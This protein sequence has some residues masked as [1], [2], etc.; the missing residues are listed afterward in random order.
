[1]PRFAF[2]AVDATGARRDGTEQAPSEAA[3]LRQLEARGLYALD[4]AERPDMRA[5][6]W[7][8][9]RRRRDVLEAT[10]AMAALLPAGLPLARALAESAQVTGLD[11]REALDDVR[12]RIERGETL[13]DALRA[14]PAHFPAFYVGIV[15]AGERS[16]DV[17]AAFGQLAA[18]L[19]R[20]EALRGRVLSATLYPAL[21]AVVGS[22][23]ILVLLGVVLPRFTTLLLDTGATLPRST[24]ALM[25][26]SSALRTAGPVLALALAAALVALVLLPRSPAGRRLG[27]EWLL[28][29]PMVGT[30]RR[31]VLGAR[32]ARLLG[33]LV[34]G[35][36]PLYVALGDVHASLDDPIARDAVLAVR[37]RVRSGAALAAALAAEPLF[38]GVLAQLVGVGETS[39]QLRLFLHKAADLLDDRTARAAQRLATLA[40]PVLIIVLGAVVAL[41]AFALLQAIY[42][43]N[44]AS[45]AT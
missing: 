4:L 42:G 7:R 45:F 43:V 33:A 37:E 9:G 18:Q 22:V 25:A 28:A 6:T 10:R 23:A 41:V 8:P 19:E 15:Q 36:A 13:A 3:L 39:S 5:R 21:L 1:M 11:V 24:R 14:W 29:L 20:A 27:A 32:V 17:A 16:G 44:A 34:G 35:G 12:A 26:V 2:E 40:E 38:P 30:W 31:Q